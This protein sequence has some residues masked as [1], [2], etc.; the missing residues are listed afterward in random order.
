MIANIIITLLVMLPCFGGIMFG[1][2]LMFDAEVI[3]GIGRFC[4]FAFL[5][6]F[7]LLFGIAGIWTIW[8]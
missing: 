8:G 2:G 7:L 6:I 3:I 1:I 4:I 5:I